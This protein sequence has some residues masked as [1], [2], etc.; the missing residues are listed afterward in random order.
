MTAGG[1]PSQAMRR[2]DM[3]TVTL[4]TSP[5]AGKPTSSARRAARSAAKAPRP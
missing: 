2:T 5:V 4:W 1:L 3:G